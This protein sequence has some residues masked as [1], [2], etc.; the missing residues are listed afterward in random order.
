[1]GKSL[2]K[3]PAFQLLDIPNKLKRQ[4]KDAGETWMREGAFCSG[5]KERGT[6]AIVSVRKDPKDN[7][8]YFFMLCRTCVDAADRKDEEAKQKALTA[9]LTEMLVRSRQ[10]KSE[11]AAMMQEAQQNIQEGKDE[12]DKQQ[13]EEQEK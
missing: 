6:P 3:K 7:A 11:L 8:N 2:R 5:C 4:A 10:G 9:P 12:H 1:M 13:A